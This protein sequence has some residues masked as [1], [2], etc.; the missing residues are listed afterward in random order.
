MILA[1][2]DHCAPGGRPDRPTLGPALF[3][4]KLWAICSDNGYC[5]KFSLYCGKV[6]RIQE[7]T[8]SPL[9]TKV[10]LNVSSVV[11]DPAGHVIFLE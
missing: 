10:V 6:N 4:Y 2:L 7:L 8:N 9:G 1:P 11:D 3:G 5:Y